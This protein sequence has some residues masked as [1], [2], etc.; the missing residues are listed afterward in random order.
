MKHLLLAIAVLACS[1]VVAAKSSSSDSDDARGHFVSWESGLRVLHFN[2]ERNTMASDG[3]IL[4]CPGQFETDYNKGRYDCL[5][6]KKQNAWQEIEWVVPRG[7]KI[8]GIDYRL[9]GSG[10]YRSLIIYFSPLP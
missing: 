4:V 2:S 8:R 5:D 9:S 7:Y 6:T 10:G 3:K 1:S